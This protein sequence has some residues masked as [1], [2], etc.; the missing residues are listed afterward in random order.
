MLCPSCHAANSEHQTY[1]GKCGHSLPVPVDA[2]T[3]VLSGMGGAAAAMAPASG[4]QMAAGLVTPPEDA[5][6]PPEAAP[7]G[8]LPPGSSFGSRYRIEALLG[9]GG[10]GAVY[11]AHDSEL[12]RTVAL[13]LVR[14]DLARSMQ[15]MQRFKQELLLASKVSHKNILR[16]HD[17][18]DM[19]GVKFITMAFVEGPDLAALIEQEGRLSFDRAL[20]FTRQLC[21]AL[22]AA[23]NE[24]VVHRD[25]KPQNILIDRNDTVYISDFGLAKSLESE[26]TMMTRTGQIVGTPRYMSP[27]QVEAGEVDHRADLYSLGLIMYEMFTADIPFRGESAIQLM[28]Q[29]VMKTPR[30]PRAACPE[31]PDYIAEI[32]LKCLEKEP[33]KRYQSA[34]EIAQDL[35]AHQAPAV[36][37]PEAASPAIRLP[38]P[39]RRWWLAGAALA[40]IA[41]IAFVLPGAR[42]LV[43]RTPAGSPAA[44][45]PGEIAHRMAVLP[46]TSV[47]DGA[48]KYLADGVAD[49]LSAKLAGLKNVYVASGNA[50]AG[51]L[52]RQR[53]PRKI[54]HALGVTLLLRGTVQSSG[55]KVSIILTLDDVS[56]QGAALLHREFPGVRQDLLTLEDQMFTAVFKSLTIKPGGDELARAAMRPTED[57]GAYDIYLKGRNLLRGKRGQKDLQDALDLFAQAH[58]R[59]PGFALAFAGEADASLLMFD[60]TKE[61]LWVQKAVSAAERAERLND[62]LPEVHFSL[63]SAYTATGKTAEGI[64]E[65][66]QALRL[67]PNSDEALRR[68]GEAYRKAGQQ[69]KAIAA[70]QEAIR[71]NPY[72]W[73]NHNFLGQA[74]FLSGENARALEAYRQVTRL[75][76][77]IPTGWANTGA[78]YYRLGQWSA[79]IPA[80]Q[81][82]I[83]LDPR[84]RYYSQVGVT[85]FFLGRYAEASAMFETAVAKNPNDAAFRVDLADAYRWSGQRDKAAATYHQAIAL[86]SASLQVNPR[87]VEAL[88]TLAICYAK[89]GDAS[90]AL[91]FIRQARQIDNK[92]NDLMYKEATVHAL[93]KR[94]SEAAASLREAL[95]NGYS[96]KEAESDPELKALRETKEFEKL[97]KELTQKDT[98]KQPLAPVR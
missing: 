75:E 41:A 8:A 30:D 44:G 92:D 18:G 54:A 36:A 55:D 10:M 9:Q 39:A 29:R 21:A 33:A 90:R 80:F 19:N 45:A 77:E 91:V 65:L 68:L 51:A 93:A 66:E 50:V 86:A 56:G 62:S 63:G 37:R 42:H 14:P 46:L 40:L 94:T 67:A 35:D 74:C 85:Y 89:N 48:L 71:V 88:G 4:P 95:L 53:D 26:A 23:H 87:N 73:A 34:R 59:D 27:E 72:F 28:Y 11:K 60:T 31:L 25:L 6:L 52:S 47:G 1:C 13:K 78:V 58:Q 49:A 12:G 70:F 43:L 83:A 69:R 17:L 79:C 22:E 82:A 32:I 3:M 38:R 81:R 97:Q 96:L 20:K 76:P 2:E 57:I 15:T 24:G 5:P 98:D 7:A 64:A 84:P 61:S 16:I